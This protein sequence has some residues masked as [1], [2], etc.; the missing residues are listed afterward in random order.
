MRLYGIGP[1][2]DKYNSCI[3][4]FETSEAAEK[5]LSSDVSDILTL[6]LCALDRAIA[7]IDPP[8]ADGIMRCITNIVHGGMENSLITAMR[9]EAEK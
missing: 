7:L 6:E 4:A 9:K 5:Y 8:K 1:C 2:A 3:F